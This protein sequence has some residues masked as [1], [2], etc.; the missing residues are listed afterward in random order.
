VRSCATAAALAFGWPAAAQSPVARPTPV[1]GAVVATRGGEELQF[2]AEQLWRP[3][4]LQQQLIGGDSVR[5]NAFGNLAI[6]FEDR[7]QVR[8]GRNSTLLVKDVARGPNGE[9]QLSL[10]SG[11]LWA[12]ASRGGS[13]VMV[14]TPAAAAAIRG[15]DWTLSAD[16]ARTA[17]VVIE[18]EVTLANPQGSVTVRQGEGAE[19]IVGQAP[20]KITLV[21]YDGRQQ[22]LLYR[23]LRDSFFDLSPTDLP[24]K[25]QR[26]ER[27]RL[28]AIPAERR[29]AEDWLGAAELALT[30]DGGAAAGRFL[31]E[32]EARGLTAAQRA[33]AELVRGFL[34]ARAAR[35]PE[36]SA[37]FAAAEGKL[38]ERRRETAAYAIWVAEAMS[39]PTRKPPPLPASS[40]YARREQG[41]LAQAS[42][43]SFTESNQRG[44][45]LLN[46]AERRFPDDALIAAAKA[47]LQLSLG[48]DDAASVQIE[49]A[50]AVDPGD[51]FVLLAGAR[52]KWTVKSDLDGAKRDVEQALAAAPGFALAWAELALVEDER[53]AVRE[54]EAAHLKSI[55]LDPDNPLM[56]ANY[57]NFLINHNQIKAA[58]PLVRRA[59]AIDPSGLVPLLTRGRLLVRQGKVAEGTAKLLAASAVNPTYADGLLELAIA[60]YNQ[61]LLEETE[62]A[63]DNADLYDSDN[64]NTPL[65]RSIIAAD[66]YR[67]DESILAARESLR[68]RLARGGY[69]ESINSDRQNGSPVNSALRFLELDEWGRYFG[70]LTFDPFNGASYFDQAT[71]TRASP[72]AAVAPSPLDDAFG[73]TAFSA[74]IQG[75]LFEPLATASSERRQ[76]LIHIPFVEAV[77]ESGVSV[78]G[79]ETGWFGSASVQGKAM[80]PTPVA[81]S[82]TASFTRPDSRY[83]N[84]RNDL[85]NA[86]AIVGAQPTA[87][88]SLILFN[89]YSK[90]KADFRSVDL[91]SV[92]P[93]YGKSESGTLGAGWSHTFAERNV[94]Q[95]LAAGSLSEQRQTGDNFIAVPRGVDVEADVDGDGVKD[96]VAFYLRNGKARSRDGVTAASHLLGIGDV[97][98]R[99]G[100]EGVF[101]RA[102]SRDAR[103]YPINGRFESLRYR[104]ESEAGLFYADA[105]WD[106]SSKVKLEAGVFASSIKAE[107]EAASCSVAEGPGCSPLRSKERE[108]EVNFRIGAAF[109]PLRGHWLRAAYREDTNFPSSIT[110]APLA[111]VG[112]LPNDLPAPIGATV[113]TLAARW[114]AEW[115]PHLFTAVEYQRQTASD[116]Y[117]DVPESLYTTN[118]LDGRLERLEATANLWLTHGFGVFAKYARTW[119]EA[120]GGGDAPF[121]AKHAGR[122]GFSFVHPSMVKLTVAQNFVGARNDGSDAFP[123]ELAPTSRLRALTTTDAALTWETLDKR[124]VLGLRGYNLFDK[125][126]VIQA[127]AFPDVA[128]PFLAPSAIEGQRRTIV[129]TARLRF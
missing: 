23:E 6:L 95:V 69:F 126:Y 102:K 72:F 17:L 80:E 61:G 86:A 82:A 77:A 29:S 114:D 79:G 33:R 57:A 109:E 91:F 122:I 9:T 35:W 118:T 49:R 4:P 128:A 78:S 1:A 43:E 38:D 5:T 115:S 123:F 15:T 76:S 88:D 74:T 101:S 8:V 40:R 54:A 25:R 71:A 81:V 92:R 90:T 30:Y 64:P 32:A 129:A 27:A 127:N 44:V 22:F 67:A 65:I 18:G 85:T 99:Y 10:P 84:D 103:F 14:D 116:L 21:D 104:S 111:T 110:L 48:E 87:Y 34:A 58:E 96:G 20:R 70:D 125:R 75:L 106:V 68:R 100:A 39:H 97:T 62:Q 12:R 11:S 45:D 31:A 2:K 50:R 112:I 46:E 53:D 107:S 117:F 13:G 73:G 37:R 42:V 56:I 108:R 83:P 105:L 36:A 66:N 98:F 24:R 121:V 63:L 47:A 3:A 59:E 41:A 16:G 52:Y 94:L 7:T 89:T 51:P 26:Q 113:R 119:S 120:E 28:A 60:Q 93:D 19:A 124:L 55:E